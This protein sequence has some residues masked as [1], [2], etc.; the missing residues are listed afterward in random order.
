MA[1]SLGR[2][3]RRAA[4]RENTIAGYRVAVNKHLIPGVGGHRLDKLQPEHLERLY[5]KM[6]EGE[7]RPAPPTRP[8]GPLEQL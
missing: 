7:A 2:D 4:V 3:H 6:Q 8:T 5:R 1:H